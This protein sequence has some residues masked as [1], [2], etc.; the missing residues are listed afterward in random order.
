MSPPASRDG[1]AIFRRVSR[2]VRTDIDGVFQ[3]QTAGSQCTR[4]CEVNEVDQ[5]VV[6]GGRNEGRSL[7][8]PV[9]A[10]G[11]EEVGEEAARVRDD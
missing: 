8:R 9:P 2:R 4:S 5:V 11:R 1:E 3:R 10:R 7:Q 6:D